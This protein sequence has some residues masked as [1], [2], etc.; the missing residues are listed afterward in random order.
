MLLS[1]YFKSYRLLI[2]KLFIEIKK[3]DENYEIPF[4]KESKV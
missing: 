3:M 2:V 1:V 4:D